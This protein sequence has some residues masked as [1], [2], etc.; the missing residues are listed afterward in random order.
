MKVL[1]VGSGGREHALAWKISQSPHVTHI[2]VAPGNGG[3]EIENNIINIDIKA[4][5]IKG[6]LA[7]AKSNEVDMTIVGP[8]DPLVKGITN[9]FEEE[10][11]M[12]FG[13][14]A[15]DLRIYPISDHLK[16]H[17]VYHLL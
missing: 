9:R 1:V 12:C 16:F 17:L 15:G 6:L 3:T 10:N 4:S 8:E 2:F 5:D 11:L 13:P 7:F 14:T